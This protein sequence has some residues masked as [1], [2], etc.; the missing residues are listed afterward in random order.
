MAAAPSWRCELAEFKHLRR[1]GPGLIDLADRV[2]NHALQFRPELIA[3]GE[4]PL[5]SKLI[6]VRRASVFK[7]LC[8]GHDDSLFRDIDVVSQPIKPS[9][10]YQ[11]CIALRAAMRA[12]WEKANEFERDLDAYDKLPHSGPP[13]QYKRWKLRQ[14]RLGVAD[15]EGVIHDPVTRL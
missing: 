4:M 1:C 6:G 15:L 3:P 5:H 2:M 14:Q 9:E 12:Y 8:A 13:E 11:R 7:L 10:D